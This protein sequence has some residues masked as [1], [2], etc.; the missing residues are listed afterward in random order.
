MIFSELYGTYYNTVAR[1]LRAATDHPLRRGELRA[2]IEENAFGESVLN[3]EPALT[4]ERWQLL[5]PNGS[6]PLHRPPTLP[7]TLTEKRWLKAIFRD[8]RIRLFTD[9]IDCFPEVEPLFSPGDIAVYDKYADGD[10][11]EDEDYIRRFRLIL[12]A[13]KNRCPLSL[14]VVN[15]NGATV[16]KVLMPDHLEYSEKDDKFRLIGTGR[17]RVETVN[18]ARIVCCAPFSGRFD[19]PAA[20]AEPP[21]KRTVEFELYDQRNALERV[22]MHFAHFEKQAVKADGGRYRVTV[23]YDRDDETEI[24]IRLLSFGPMIR[25]TA[26]EHCVEL[27]RARLLRQ[28]SCGH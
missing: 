9:E 19:P 6:T 14:E 15:R 26:P 7:L 17:R 23:S 10:P 8:P 25:V 16:R 2:I 27:I 21:K 22:L 18:L 13:I 20:K 1:I 4:E 28:K 12:D 5:D 11:Y 3:I 24:V